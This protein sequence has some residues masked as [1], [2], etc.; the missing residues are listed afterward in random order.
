MENQVTGYDG[1]FALQLRL[2]MNENPKTGHTVTQKELGEAVGVRPQTISLYINGN[3]QPTP[4]TLVKMAE[5]FGVSVDYLLTGISSEN[6]D[7][8]ATLGLSEDAI[9]M[10]KRAHEYS[11]DTGEFPSPIALINN[12]FADKAFYEFLEELGYKA[13]KLRILQRHTEEKPKLDTEPDLEGYYIYDMQMY[14]QEFIR[15]Q[16]VKHGLLIDVK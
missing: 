13:I 12:L 6:M 1:T 2:L 15:D 16:L 7:I 4:D 10:L 14:V 11:K 3:T 9:V 5:F 8:N